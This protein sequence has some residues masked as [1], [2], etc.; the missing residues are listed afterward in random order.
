[1]LAKL[2]SNGLHQIYHVYDK[3]VH[4][5]VPLYAIIYLEIRER[6]LLTIQPNHNI[7]TIA[8]LKII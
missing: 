1:M 3:L 8:R 6:R 5:E 7:T 2:H 4:L